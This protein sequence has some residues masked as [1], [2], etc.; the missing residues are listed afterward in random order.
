VKKMGRR[1]VA[2]GRKPSISLPG[3]PLKGLLGG[4]D[5]DEDGPS[6]PQET[7]KVN[8]FLSEIESIVGAKPVDDPKPGLHSTGEGKEINKAKE[9]SASKGPWQKVWD[10][11][12]KAYYYWHSGTNVV[13]WTE[14]ADFNAENKPTE[15]PAAHVEDGPVPV[16]GTGKKDAMKKPTRF[17]VGPTDIPV[18]P[19]VLATKDAKNDDRD[20]KDK[21][22]RAR[23]ASPQ[24]SEARPLKSQK[25]DVEDEKTLSKVEKAKR[26]REIMLKLSKEKQE[27]AVADVEKG[28]KDGDMKTGANEEV[29]GSS[30]ESSHLP[31]L[32]PE[33]VEVAEDA[34]EALARAEIPDLIGEVKQELD[35]LK[36]TFNLGFDPIDVFDDHAGVKFVS[37]VQDCQFVLRLREFDWKQEKCGL[38]STYFADSLR[39][40][41][42]K[43]QARKSMAKSNN[44]VAAAPAVRSSGI[45]VLTGLEKSLPPASGDAEPYFW[46][47]YITQDSSAALWTSEQVAGHFGK[48][49][50]LL[51]VRQIGQGFFALE[52]SERSNVD[53]QI[54]LT[55]SSMSI[56]SSSTDWRLL[57]DRM[58]YARMGSAGDSVMMYPVT[59]R[60]ASEAPKLFTEEVITV[61]KSAPKPALVSAAVAKTGTKKLAQDPMI[62]KWKAARAEI[63]E[64]ERKNK[65]QTEMS[66]EEMNEHKEEDLKAWRASVASRYALTTIHHIMDSALYDFMR[67]SLCCGTVI[68][69]FVDNT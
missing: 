34:E 57:S 31:P 64:Y 65:K 1:P 69:T 13:S 38:R 19:V 22:K 15:T 43:I 56:P 45:S 67:L 18:K 3:N 47:L 46:L 66:Y 53:V 33:P 59:H 39:L 16:G 58:V 10:D 14:P 29:P 24:K 28:S 48:L 4:Y 35:S 21:S 42:Q 27:D 52:F 60:M 9:S 8:D 50:D 17:G 61:T 30:V 51:A 11:T 63:E 37:S 49:R 32:P 6:S 36:S 5:D 2:S 20:C 62:N 41:L 7:D 12:H 26:V 55:T 23:S 44:V 68:W 54:Q 40:M 25:T